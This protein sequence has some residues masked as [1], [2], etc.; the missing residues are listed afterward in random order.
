MPNA[1]SSAPARRSP[2]GAVFRSRQASR[3]ERDR[4]RS[5][6]F[7]F[8]FSA[9]REAEDDQF[10]P[11]SVRAAARALAT[12][13]ADGVAASSA[14]GGAGAAP[15]DSVRDTSPLLS[16]LEKEVVLDAVGAWM[17]HGCG[18]RE[19]TAI[20]RSV[21]RK[22]GVDDSLFGTEMDDSSIDD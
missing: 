7:F 12:A 18:A 9:Q 22:I 3:F 17:D 21:L 16:D 1:P 2:I 20:M 6:S 4:I 13:L 19:D 5:T 11:E 8:S 15:V 14:S 10:P